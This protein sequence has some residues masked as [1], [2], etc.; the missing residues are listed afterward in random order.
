MVELTIGLGAGWQLRWACRGVAWM[1]GWG[2]WGC[3][4]LPVVFVVVPRRAGDLYK[5]IRS[6]EWSLKQWQDQW[7]SVGR[8]DPHFQPFE[9]FVGTLVSR[10]LQNFVGIQLRPQPNFFLSGLWIRPQILPKK[11]QEI[12]KKS[13]KINPLCNRPQVAQEYE[14]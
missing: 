7:L 11:G 8:S 12:A 14:Y 1:R 10:R 13:H 3:L 2:R 4:A 9:N 6:A 5:F